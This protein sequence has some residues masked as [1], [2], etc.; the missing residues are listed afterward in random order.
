MDTI[1]RISGWFDIVLET[2][3]NLHDRNDTKALKE[4]K[5]ALEVVMKKNTQNHFSSAL[6]LLF[7][8][9]KKEEYSKLTEEKIA[10]NI[11]VLKK[12]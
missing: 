10:N 11:Y 8:R 5:R 3:I 6:D 1:N 12:K 9:S 7:S 2:S 4:A